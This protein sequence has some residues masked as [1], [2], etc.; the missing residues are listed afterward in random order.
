M[1]M[2]TIY[3]YNEDT[4]ACMMLVGYLTEEEALDELARLRKLGVWAFYRIEVLVE[5]E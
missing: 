5:A 3:T 1:E 4:R 2:F